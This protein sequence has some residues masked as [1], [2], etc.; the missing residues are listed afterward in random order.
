MATVDS[1]CELL[2]KA[3]IPDKLMDKTLSKLEDEYVVEVQDLRDLRKLE[4]GLN[5]IFPKLA[6]SRIEDALDAFEQ[7]SLENLARND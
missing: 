4:G 1:L 2:R 3:G 7:L 6:A 5:G